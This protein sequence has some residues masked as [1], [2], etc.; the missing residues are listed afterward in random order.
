[1][2]T[3]TSDKAA[4]PRPPAVASITLSSTTLS[5]GLG[6]RHAF[7]DTPRLRG[8]S[9]DGLSSRREVQRQEETV[10]GAHTSEMIC[11]EGRRWRD[12][13]FFTAGCT[14]A[15]LVLLASGWPPTRSNAMAPEADG[16]G[17]QEPNGLE[18]ACAASSEGEADE[19]PPAPWRPSGSQKLSTAPTVLDPPGPSYWHVSSVQVSPYAYVLMAYDPP[20]E[21]PQYIWQ[22]IAIC[23]SIQR[24]SRYPAILLT[25]TTYLP[26]GTHVGETFWKLNTQVLPVHQV[27]VPDN[28]QDMMPGA[29]HKAFWKLQIWRLTQYEK[30]IWVD[31]D[32]VM[33]RS[34]D[35]LFQR[36]PTWGQRDAVC[37]NIDDSDDRL[38][39]GLMLIEPS[40]DTYHGLLDYAADPAN[41]LFNNGDQKLIH[42]YHKNVAGHP[43]QLLNLTEAAFGECLGTIPSLFQEASGSSWTIP[44]FVHKSSQGNECF[45]FLISEQLH[46]VEGTVVNVCHHHPLGPHWRDVFCDGLRILG[47]S[48]D[49]TDAFCDDF[50]WYRDR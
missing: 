45:N 50:T 22:A 30:L 27:P 39:S 23:R 20:D 3:T 11:A 41:S 9:K 18:W 17:W 44:A 34:L 6:A 42:E 47:V 1:M 26:D 43:V 7:F 38:C 12:L 4:G 28:I 36:K 29:W 2:Q 8:Q 5:S 21:P 33:F 24:L 37:S 15:L 40:E 25:N 31:T 32:A 14:G 49:A 35:Y 19:R 16:N 10:S 13:T 46:E 48:T